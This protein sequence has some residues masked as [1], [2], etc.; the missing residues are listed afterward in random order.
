MKPVFGIEGSIGSLEIRYG[1][2]NGWHPHKHYGLLFNKWMNE[3]DRI[4]LE[5]ELY[6]E[7]EKEL[8]KLGAHASRENGVFLSNPI[9]DVEGMPKRNISDYIE[10]WGIADELLMGGQKEG[11][12]VSINQLFLMYAQDKSEFLKQL[13]LEYWQAIKGKR[14]AVLHH[15][16][17]K[18]LGIVEKPADQ[19]EEGEGLQGEGEKMEKLDLNTEQWE[20]VRKNDKI[21]FITEMAMRTEL[22]TVKEYIDWLV[23]KV[24]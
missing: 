24:V 23:K 18:L 8:N 20:A 21:E 1:F 11:K 2:E 13:L 14:R 5:S 7:Y 6:N 10:K 22:S 3:F 4:A 15:G 17:G 12:S 9:V 16:T 19:V